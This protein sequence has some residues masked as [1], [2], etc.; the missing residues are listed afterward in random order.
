MKSNLRIAVNAQ[1]L[2]RGGAGGI[3]T[4]LRQLAALGQLEDGDEEYVFV[5]HW[6]DGGEWLKPFLTERQTV[7]R[8]PQ[9]EKTVQIFSESFRNSMGRLRPLARRVKRVF[10]PMPP[11]TAAATRFFVPS[12]NGFYESLNCDVVHFP[13]QEYVFCE[14]PTV[15]NPHDL[16][17]L[18]FPQF[19]SPDEFARRET[20]YRAACAAAKYVA[21]ASRFVKRDI[22]ENYGIDADKIQII[23]WAAP[24]ANANA[25]ENAGKDGES[26]VLQKYEID[27]D[28]PFAIYPA[29]TWE[30]KNHIR[31]LEAIALLRDGENLKIN[32]VCTG[33]RN[34]FFPVIERRLRELK[35]DEQVKFTGVVSLEE[36][37]A[38][39]FRAR[40][41]VVPTLFEA[42]SAPLFEA[43]QHDVAVACSTVTSLP[44]QAA[45]AALL[46][47]PL[48]VEAIADALKKMN[49]DE[50]LR[51][52]LR[53][54]GAA[55]LRD[56]SRE[57][58]LKS[59]RA[60]Y[61][62]AAGQKL[63]DEDRYLLDT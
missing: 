49:S 2:A 40:F 22:E 31:L 60:L 4:V 25:K 58:T 19:F 51:A 16:Q 45:G 24:P 26:L 56:F 62:K 43:W 44:E 29:M 38:L 63:N 32:L 14:Q 52:T 36:L 57:R 41:V 34:A 13:Y 35:L 48:S 53:A 1:I 46:F 27:A 42:A 6:S 20:V 8:A 23:R 59:Y 39:Y 12:S 7:V 54:A 5:G 15:Y 33:D 47:N 17:H 3:V 28:Q 30:H 55:R 10:T 9:P 61:R 18:H 50:P 21:V 37:S 11:K